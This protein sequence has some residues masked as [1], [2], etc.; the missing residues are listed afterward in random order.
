MP[1]GWKWD[2]KTVTLKNEEPPTYQSQQEAARTV[3][4]E[5]QALGYE[6]DNELTPQE[7]ADQASPKQKREWRR[8]IHAFLRRTKQNKYVQ[9]DEHPWRNEL[10]D[11]DI[12][13]LLE[14]GAA[15]QEED[16]VYGAV[17]LHNP[18]DRQAMVEAVEG[19]TER[20]RDKGM[21]YDPR[22]GWYDP[23]AIDPS[24]VYRKDWEQGK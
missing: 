15:W 10:R 22:I 17:P 13:G 7:I 18:R 2:G 21:T 1:I 5:R 14:S 8:Q 20:M 3:D 12:E 16:G 6:Y 4:L 24:Q 11:L 23:R 19:W 9:D